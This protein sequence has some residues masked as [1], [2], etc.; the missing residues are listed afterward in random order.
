MKARDLKKGDR[1]NGCIVYEDPRP[2]PGVPGEIETP[3]LF[4]IWMDE[5]GCNTAEFEGWHYPV[6]HPL[7]WNEDEDLRDVHEVRRDGVQIWP[8]KR[9]PK[10]LDV[11]YK[12]EALNELENRSRT[13][14][15]IRKLIR[16]EITRIE[17]NRGLPVH[18]WTVAEPQMPRRIRNSGEEVRAQWLSEN[19]PGVWRKR[20]ANQ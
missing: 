19:S 18:Q 7:T 10:T 15:L 14:F 9:N 12:I 16:N 2:R 13:K 5:S 3:I 4:D 6:A 1:I 8:E 20:Y 11:L 17:T